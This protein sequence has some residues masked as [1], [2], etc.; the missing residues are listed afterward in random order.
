[1]VSLSSQSLGGRI[2]CLVLVHYSEKILT[3]I[4]EALNALPFFCAFDCSPGLVVSKLA[5]SI[6]IS[7]YSHPIIIRPGIRC[8]ASAVL[9][10]RS[11]ILSFRIFASTFVSISIRVSSLSNYSL[12]LLSCIARRTLFAAFFSDQKRS[13]AFYLMPRK[14]L[15]S[16]LNSS[17]RHIRA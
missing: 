3:L 16:H 14:A 17:I 2:Q 1:M 13:F 6:P 10:Y 11:S 9:I 5:C 7:A 4:T 15:V 12:H 8:I